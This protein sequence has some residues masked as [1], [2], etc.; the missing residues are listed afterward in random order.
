MGADHGSL[1]IKTQRGLIMRT[2]PGA[3]NFP[4][5]SRA[6]LKRPPPPGDK[7]AAPALF[8]EFCLLYRENVFRQR[9]GVIVADGPVRRHRD[10]TPY[11]GRALFD[12]LP[13]IAF[14][15]PSVLFLVRPV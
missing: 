14:A 6:G 5:A 4:G 15:A 11:A 7:P 8:D 3:V 10:G 12:V 9:L 1:R 13:H 2:A